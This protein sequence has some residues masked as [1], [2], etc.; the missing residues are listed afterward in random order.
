MSD[1]Q[2]HTLPDFDALVIVEI[3]FKFRGREYILREAD[4]DTSIKHE[5]YT[6]S[7]LE[8]D[9]EGRPKGTKGNLAEAKI[10]LL[11]G[12]TFERYEDK[13]EIKERNVPGV[14]IRKWP[15]RLTDP[16]YQK[17]LDISELNV[18]NVEALKKKLEEDK[19]RIERLE[20]LADAPKN[21]PS[22]TTELA[23]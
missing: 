11:S 18:K 16:L 19:K 12:C 6:T 23:P 1:Q 4:A 7:C 22:G 17:A 20:Q 3:P 9:S 2:E 13:G 21:E 5:G 10:V 15:A 8:L 14:V